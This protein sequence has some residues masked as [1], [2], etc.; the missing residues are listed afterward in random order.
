MVLYMSKRPL[1]KLYI[2]VG[3]EKVTLILMRFIM[4]KLSDNQELVIHK[5]QCEMSLRS[6]CQNDADETGDD[7]I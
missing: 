2:S 1:I 6:Y 3:G 5:I 4:S 7:G